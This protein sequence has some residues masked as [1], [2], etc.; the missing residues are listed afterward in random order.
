MSRDEPH[1][2][3]KAPPQ[4][5]PGW[6]EFDKPLPGYALAVATVVAGIGL[7]LAIT[8][9]AGPGLPTFITFY[10]AVMITA[11]MAGFGPGLAA[12]L[13]AAIAA[14]RWAIPSTD[15]LFHMAVVDIASLPLFLAMGLLMSAVANRY[16]RTR[17]KAAAYDREAARRESEAR[18]RRVFDNAGTGIALTDC[19]G[20]FVQCNALYCA[21]TGYEQHELAA[22]EFPALIHPADREENTASI[23]RLLAGEV[24]SFEIENRYVHK[25]G[26][27][28]WVHNHVSLLRDD[29]GAPAQ[30]IALV[31]DRTARRRT[32][33]TLRFLSQ[34]GTR[35]D[36]EGFFPELARYLAEALEMDFVCIDRL[37]QG[38]LAARTLAMFNNGRFEDNV[39][40]ALKDTPCGDVV[41]RRVCCFP[42]NV[43][44]LFP[45]DTVL[46]DLRAEGYL[47]VTLWDSQGKPI[48]LIATICRR[49]LADTRLSEAILQMVAVRAA[50]ELERQ[51][52]ERQLERLNRTLRAMSHSGR[53]I[54]RATGE[55]EMLEAACRIVVEDCG[56]AMAWIGFAEEDEGRT[57]RPAA[58]AGF[59]AGY[60]ETLEITWA[61]S[62]RGRGPTGTAIRTGKPALCRDM[63]N[64]PAFAP[65]RE[66]AR[67]RGYSSSLVLPLLDKERAF[68]AV[69]IYSREANGFSEDEVGLLT[70]LAADLAYGI[71]VLRLREAHALGEEAVRRAKEEWERTFDTV[72]DMIAILDDDHH[73][74]R[75]NRAMARRLGTSQAQCVG[76]PCYAVVHGTGCPPGSC[77]HVQTLA[78]R[79]QHTVELHESRLG[80]DVLVSTTPMFGADG[81]MT[82]SVHVARDITEQ[83]RTQREREMSVEFLR[84]VN[85]SVGTADLVRSAARFFHAKS[86]CEAV[87]IR[88]KAGDDYP[89]VESRGFPAEFIES[90][91]DLCARDPQGQPVFG[92]DGHPIQECMC[93]NVIQG[94]FD[95]GKPF[96]TARGS[97]WCNSTTDLLA[98]TTEADRQARTRNRCNGEGYESVAL[99]A[100]RAGGERFGLI[101]FNDKRRNQFTP[102]GIA[103]WERLA[104]YLAVALAK[105]RADEALRESRERLSLSEER[106]RLTFDHSP[107]GK[108]MMDGDLRTRRANDALCAF[109]GYSRD[110]IV[111]TPLTQFVHPD[112]RTVETARILSVRNGAC[113]S[114]DGDLRFVRK[115]GTVVWGHAVMHALRD[116]AGRPLYLVGLVQDLTARKRAEEEIRQ[117]NATLERRVEERTAEAHLLAMQ[118]R[119]LASEL[120]QAEQRERKRLAAILHDHIQQLLV[121]AR[122]Q[123]GWM[124]HDTR[125]QKALATA[126]GVDSILKEALDASRSLAVELSPPVLHTAGL[127]GGLSWL[128]A[129]AKEKNQ[130]TVH[131]RAD[132]KAEPRAEAMALLLFECA[133]ELLLN[134]VKHSGAAEAHVT[135]LRAPDGRIKLVVRD[136]G[137]GFDPGLLARRKPGETSFGLFSIQQR[138][139]HAGGEVEIVTAPG[140][141]A[142][143]SVAIA[144]DEP[145]APDAASPEPSEPPK[146]TVEVSVRD[147]A[148]ATRVLLVDDHRIMREGL[149]GLLQF[150]PDIEV[151]GQAADGA[152]AI[153]MAADLK[154][155]VIVMDVDLGDMSGIE[156]TRRILAVAPAVKVIGLSMH[157]DEDV[158]A[159]LHA[160]GASAY[161]TKGGPSDALVEA[162]R[163]CRPK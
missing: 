55:K 108:M 78:D 121:A 144:A 35:R 160:A 126:Q 90:E 107:V 101:Q 71:I 77:P 14:A 23:R 15:G 75:V 25:S 155:D 106:F 17:D 86:G 99:I 133:R 152:Q 150:E 30:I 96:F 20:R 67:K 2:D 73:I 68:G 47:G 139:A 129:R 88:L 70:E 60:I 8:A 36:G 24:P 105:T 31:T 120:A 13:L 53:A 151:V 115:D 22:M 94:R 18:F 48:G 127:I 91:N 32:E 89:Y 61:D 137:K 79:L 140:K 95:P 142:S 44:A 81:R 34:C 50:A 28:V 103:L 33:E 122:M 161:L 1:P 57:V 87:G 135:L 51:E 132:S 153:A 84:L 5:R 141:G 111:A 16:R 102:E 4:S 128:A 64:D 104:D 37:E 149:V 41:G 39:S 72:P 52:A 163:A 40:Y 43:R 113:A 9:F 112:E 116:K 45:K 63:Q 123:I 154:P 3:A 117:L 12:T 11:L 148:A 118:L 138:L 10:P 109:L 7:R 49:P 159:A 125:S 124:R 6:A 119:A 19:S 74:I 69:T 27:V 158:I 110:E 82:G 21:L 131:L 146:K 92:R 100:L 147:R 26:R 62:E 162:I 58:S 65:W 85:E 134:A 66:E 156:A 29:R 42:R 98:A 54:A 157:A 83:K 59:E 114:Y 93:G 130:F 56:H 145:A 46:Q 76:L 136:E 38:N 80:G 143:V 97:F